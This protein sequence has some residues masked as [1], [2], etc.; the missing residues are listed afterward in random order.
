MKQY[1]VA[2][3]MMEQLAK[4]QQYKQHAQKKINPEY[5]TTAQAMMAPITVNKM[6]IE[7]VPQEFSKMGARV[8][9]GAIHRMSNSRRTGNLAFWETSTMAQNAQVYGARAL[10]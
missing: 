8:E 6:E 10:D 7:S 9:G 5:T 3:A 2:T 4:A 1:T